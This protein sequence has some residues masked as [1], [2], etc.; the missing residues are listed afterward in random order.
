MSTC[1]IC[2]RTIKDSKGVIAHHGY[3]RPG[4]GWQTSS[5]MGA[6]YPAYEQS[7]DRIPVAIDSIQTFIENSAAQLDRLV[8]DPPEGFT[9]MRGRTPVQVERPANF[10]PAKSNSYIPF[11]YANEYQNRI[12]GLKSAIRSARIDLKFLEERLAAWVA[13]EPVT[14][15]DLQEDH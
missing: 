15:N 11:S 5:C 4:N 7:C 3:E 9:I 12:R 14:Y 10:D 8:N 13:P 1:Q 2:A 6:R